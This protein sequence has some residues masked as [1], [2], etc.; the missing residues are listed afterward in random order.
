M[1]VPPGASFAALLRKL[2]RDA[3][4]TQEELAE[5][6]RL[7]HRSISDLE[8]GINL[9]PRKETTRL[10]ADA[11]R[12]VG[13]EREAFEA[14][15]RGS[16]QPRPGS[17]VPR[18]LPEQAGNPIEALSSA[19]RAALTNP[20]ISAGEMPAG[21]EI[22]TLEEGYIDQ[23][24]RI[25]EVT[26]AAELGRESWWAEV[27]VRDGACR[28][29]IAHL[30]AARYVAARRPDSTGK[31]RRRLPSELTAP[32]ILLGQPGSGKSV[33]TRIL[34]ARLPTADFLPVRVELRK[35][36]VKADMQHQI[37]LAVRSA[38]G[39]SVE[40]PRLVE[41]SNR[42]LPV[43]MLD[44]FDELLQATGV[45]H[46]NFLERVQEFQEREA[47]LNRPLAVIVTSRTVVTNRV[48]IPAGATAI[49]LEPFSKE[50]ITAWLE[51]WERTNHISLAKRDMRPLPADI[52]L[53]Y[54]ELA[55]QPLLL[56]MLAL[57]DADG[58]ALQQRSA[59][60]GQTELYG[61]LLKDFASREIRK[62]FSA[63]PEADLESAVEAE[64]FRLS[65]IAFAMFNRRSQWVRETDID[66]DL[67]ELRV[68]GGPGML[69]PGRL[70]TQLTA[71]QLTVGR[72][73]FVHESQQTRTYEFLHATFGEFLVARL[74]VHVLS[75]MRASDTAATPP[76]S[77]GIDDGM[78]Y[79]LLSFEALTDRSTIVAFVGDLLGQLDA[80]HRTDIADLLLQLHTRALFPHAKSLY[81]GYEPLRLTVTARHCAW[82]ANLVVLAVLADGEISGSQLFPQEA[83]PVLAWRKEAMM[84]RSQLSGHGWEGLYEM[85]A[86]NRVW[87]GGRRE[88]RLSRNDGTF[89]V[90]APDI[91]WTYNIPP[92]PTVRKGIFA[93]RAHNSH[94][95]RRKVN[96]VCNMSEDTMAHGLV[97]VS[98]SFPAVA[99]VFVILD[100]DRV[101]SAAH[102]LLSVLYAPYQE[103]AP[104]FSVYLDLAYVARKLA[105]TPNIEGD[106]S[107]LKAALAVLLSAVER[108]AAPTA[109]LE[110]LAGMASDTIPED[111][112]LTELLARLDI[113]LSGHGVDT[114]GSVA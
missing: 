86:L 51:V 13:A 56:L 54:E 81:S 105:Q 65:V 46:Y 40:W 33:L 30:T 108:G 70:E 4:L 85:I 67:R 21:L 87:D 5:A 106:N 78:L 92:D 42:A 52:V 114:G 77:G 55:G 109:S 49:R 99:N 37:E 102:A 71:A 17:P 74:V 98:S 31:P 3:G 29:L 43:V 24:I 23:R 12:L 1:A 62:H 10:L 32:L 36:P 57:Y 35:S 64:L 95:M 34:A 80:Q 104:E 112:K 26:P 73:F 8:R 6:A 90:D 18:Q 69:E 111:A 94:T 11:L 97:P 83:D 50:Q 72:F 59:A 20:I 93:S 110:P 53:N 14:V 16:V 88:F 15:A 44:G 9:T 27:P 75:E 58:N 28:F 7:H 103:D 91:Y 101:V 76:L 63:L 2:R 68:D 66:T 113:L 79:A 96:F 48:R 22:P 25:A 100:E 19:Y 39:E 41:S 60:L 89:T 61:R 84:W 82:S 47:D 107:Y 38:T 45:A